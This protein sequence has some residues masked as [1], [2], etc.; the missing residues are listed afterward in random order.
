MDD[1]PEQ[2]QML[3][4]MMG[5]TFF[6]QYMTALCWAVQ[7]VAGEV[8]NGVPLVTW[9][10]K[11]LMIIALTIGLML[12]GY[13]IASITN[14]VANMDSVTQKGGCLPATRGLREQAGAL[15]GGDAPHS[16]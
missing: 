12:G 7:A 10:Q 5:R 16:C 11:F 4:P 2:A 13:I 8:N 15:H 1:D 14:L 9:Y 6:D 3:R